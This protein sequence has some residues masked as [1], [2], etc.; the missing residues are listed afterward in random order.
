MLKVDSLLKV[1]SNDEIKMLGIYGP[2]GLGKTTLAKAI[3][4]II[5]DQFECLC[6]LH[7]VREKSAKHGLDFRASPKGIS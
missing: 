3:Y 4:N 5:A 7:N 1:G 6:F 2:G